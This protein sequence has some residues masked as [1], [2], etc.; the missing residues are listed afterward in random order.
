MNVSAAPRC[1]VLLAGLTLVLL[2]PGL[3]PAP[4]ALTALGVALALA[5]P[6]LVGSTVASAGFVV[7]W[8]AGSGW[9]DGSVPLWRTLAAAAALYLLHAATSLSACVPLGASVD[10]GVFRGWAA[11]S[12][13]PV[14]CAAV[15]VALDEA[16]PRAHGTV[17]TELAGLIG[18]VVLAAVV[19]VVA[20]ARRS[21]TPAK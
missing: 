14:G 21:D 19:A 17:L 2:L 18:V 15:I 12:L 16:V 10:A 5:A 7:G 9:D 3:P 4:V 20:A 11:R 8:L 6:R 13:L 1:L